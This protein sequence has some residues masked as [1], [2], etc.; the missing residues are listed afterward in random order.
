MNIA[1]TKTETFVLVISILISAISFLIFQT[2]K[3]KASANTITAAS[4]SQTDVQNAIN[5][6]S[7]GDTVLVPAGS[8][9]WSNGVTIGSI[10]KR[11]K[12]FV[13][14]VLDLI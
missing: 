2:L 5:S 7:D 3:A 11:G 8:C 6:A 14:P 9:V 13:F 1:H 12:P 10:A 4:C